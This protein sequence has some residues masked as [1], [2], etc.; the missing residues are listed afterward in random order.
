MTEVVV[1]VFQPVHVDDPYDD[2]VVG[3]NVLPAAAVHHFHAAAVEQTRHG[4]VYRIVDE[5][6]H[7]SYHVQ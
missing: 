7:D 1:D 5:L 3:S 4:V 2:I 6:A